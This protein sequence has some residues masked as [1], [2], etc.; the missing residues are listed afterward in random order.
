[1]RARGLVRHKD[2]WVTQEAKQDLARLEAAK[3]IEE[4]RVEIERLKLQQIQA[5]ADVERAR[6]ESDRARAWLY[7]RGYNNGYG[8]GN[9]YGTVY[10]G[11]GYYGGSNRSRNRVKSVSVTRQVPSNLGRVNVGVL[12]PPGFQSTRPQTQSLPARHVKGQ[13]HH[14]GK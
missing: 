2:I 11:G 8:Y 9:G 5:R 7:N 3:Q 1:M 10:Y 4:T 14:H 13:G 6:A 12:L